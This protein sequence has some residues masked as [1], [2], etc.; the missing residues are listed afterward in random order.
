MDPRGRRHGSW[1]RDNTSRRRESWR[2][3][4]CHCADVASTWQLPRRHN[5]W[6]RARRQL[7]RRPDA[8][9]AMALHHRHA[10]SCP[11]QVLCHMTPHAFLC[12]SVFWP[13]AWSFHQDAYPYTSLTCGPVCGLEKSTPNICSLIFVLVFFL[14]PHMYLINLACEIL[15]SN[16]L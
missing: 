13:Y 15:A 7:L 3:D 5:R 9:R 11:T 16:Q 6:R 14:L 1:R 8:P 4:I 12:L 10:S 2:R